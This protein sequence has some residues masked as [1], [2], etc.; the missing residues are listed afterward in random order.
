[1][2]RGH[3]KVS[4]S[5]EHR[6][7]V[8]DMVNDAVTRG[9]TVLAGGRALPDLGEAFFLAPTVLTNVAKR[10]KLYREEVFG[11]VVYVEKYSRQHQRGH[12]TR[13]RF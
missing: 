1:M 5:A 8:E 3:G 7:R 2:G 9:A 13:Q 6:E 4:I 11:P 12:S 10:S